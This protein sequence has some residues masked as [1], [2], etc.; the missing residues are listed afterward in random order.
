[1]LL[2]LLLGEGTEEGLIRQKLPLVP[3]EFQSQSTAAAVIHMAINILLSLYSTDPL[4]LH[5]PGWPQMNRGRSRYCTGLC[6]GLV[7]DHKTDTRPARQW[8]CCQRPEHSSV[9]RVHTNQC[10]YGVL[11]ERK[12][13][14]APYLMGQSS[15]LMRGKW[16]KVSHQLPEVMTL[17][18]QHSFY[19]DM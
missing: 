4:L 17:C 16:Q 15:R 3:L 13:L 19:N 10:R 9:V 2:L 18:P 5:T 11:T 12:I 8:R 14:S 6:Y 7:S 1:M